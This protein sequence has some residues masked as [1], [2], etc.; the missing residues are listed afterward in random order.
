MRSAGS[1]DGANGVKGAQRQRSKAAA[2]TGAEGREMWGEGRERET[3]LICSAARF[4][5]PCDA[6]CTFYN[7]FNFI[8]SVARLPEPKQSRP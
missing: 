3:A 2:D 8:F 7:K 6:F 5:F 4:A 1:G